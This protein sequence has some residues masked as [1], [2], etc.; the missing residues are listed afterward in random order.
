MRSRPTALSTAG[1]LMWHSLPEYLRDPAVGTRHRHF[2]QPSEYVFL[3]DV[4]I[5]SAL[6]VF[7]DD[8]LYKPTFYLLT[9]I[10]NT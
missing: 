8:A 1:P 2:L 7:Y 5:Y 3:R 6:D 10:H 4:L 9:Y